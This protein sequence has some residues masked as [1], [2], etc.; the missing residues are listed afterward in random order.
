MS[1]FKVVI[2]NNG[3]SPESM[4]YSMH[5]KLQMSQL[6]SYG[7]P[8]ITSGAMNGSVPIIWCVDFFLSKVIA[9]PKSA[10]LA[11]VSCL[12]SSESTIFSGFMSRWTVLFSCRY[13]SPFAISNDSVLT[14]YSGIVP[15]FQC[16]LMWSTRSPPDWYSLTTNCCSLHSNDSVNFTRF[17]WLC[18][19]RIATSELS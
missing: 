18:V 19:E 7:F 4:P 11:T 10:I 1:K 9:E 14:V 13:W 6:K 12:E 3:C 17:S 5:P 15:L 16:F 2:V 8:A